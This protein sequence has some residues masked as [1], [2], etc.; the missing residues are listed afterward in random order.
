M[1]KKMGFLDEPNSGLAL[2]Q[3]AHSGNSHII[4][5]HPHCNN[6]QSCSEGIKDDVSKAQIRLPAIIA[7]ESTMMK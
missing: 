2:R 6:P 3:V 5:C 1:R 7:S 4:P